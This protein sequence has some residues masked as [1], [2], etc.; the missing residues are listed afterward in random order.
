MVSK[1]DSKSFSVGS[2]PTEATMATI[3]KHNN[4]VY[5]CVNLKKKLKRLRIDESDIEILFE[6]ELSQSELEK[7]YLEL[8]QT[9]EDVNDNDNVKLYH[10]INPKTKETITSIYPTLE[11]LG[12][13]GEGFELMSK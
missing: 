5:Q 9:N 4:E 13:Y 12:K 3:F 10:F 1:G 6:S 11:G 2:N 7:K 8:T